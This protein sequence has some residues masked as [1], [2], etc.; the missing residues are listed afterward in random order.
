[1]NWRRH[2]GMLWALCFS[3]CL[4]VWPAS[5]EEEPQP[6]AKPA[7]FSVTGY[8][9]LGNRELKL[10]VRSLELGKT[11]PEY[12]GAAFVEDAALLLTSRVKRDGYLQ[13]KI[14]VKLRLSNGEQRKFSADELAADPLPRSLQ[15]VEVDFHIDGGRRYYFEKIEF[16]GLQI[17]S[18]KQALSYFVETDTLLKTAATRI[19]TPDRLKRGIASL[20][21]VLERR[22][23]P[24]AKAELKTL[25]KD[26][27]TGAVSVSI[28][29]REGPLHVVHSVLKEVKRENQ[30]VTTTNQFV[31][32]PYSKLWLQDFTL[33]LNRDLYREGYPDATAT[34]R[35]TGR[36]QHTNHVD[37]DLQAQVESGSQ[38]TAGEVRFEG[39]QHT[40]T[41]FM[42]RRIPVEPGKPLNRLQAEKGRAQLVELGIFDSVGLRYEERDNNIRDLIYEVDEGTRLNLSVLFGWGSYEMLRGGLIVDAYNIWGR[43]HHARIKAIQSLRSSRGEFTYT[44][45]AYLGREVDLFFHGA[46]LRREEVDFTRQ[47]YGGGMGV[48]KFFQEIG[49]DVTVRY[50]YEILQALHTIPGVASEGLISPA[51]GSIIADFKHDR[52][53]NPLYPR[54]GYKVFLTLESASEYLGGDAN[55]ERVEISPS[56]HLRLGGGRFLSLGASHGVVISHGAISENLPFNRRFFPGGDH[57]IRGYQEGE[58]SPRNE[59]R[60]FVGAE[61]YTLGTVELEQALT[62]KWAL[63]GFADALG[64]ARRLGDYPFDTGLFSVGGGIRWRT[65]IGPV[66]LEYAHNLNP[67]SGDPDWTIHFSL[68]FPF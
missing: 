42:E 40:S 63:V 60:R 59:E 46:G 41:N 33:S 56:W 37:L 34:T 57:S 21:E 64:V 27:R 20:V 66:R 7:R 5:A 48:H 67:R 58:A 47:E 62:P 8:G 52:R 9:L 17:L 38:I 29:V 14:T 49:T 44:I 25:E 61:T 24:E 68:G 6:K 13:P 11:K 36:E 32:K 30:A 51:V 28:Q 31:G 10:K 35:I 1:M 15:I 43:A 50:N 45:P 19:Y 2:G 55:Y 39:Q 4:V 22:G 53:D 65:I 54:R 3:L 23:Y 26:D 12:L 16:T 18:R